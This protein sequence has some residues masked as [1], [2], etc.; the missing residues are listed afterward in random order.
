MMKEAQKLMNENSFRDDV[1][2]LFDGDF[3]KRNLTATEIPK[4]ILNLVE[5]D[6]ALRFEVIPVAFDSYDTLYL[7]T[8]A[9]NFKPINLFTT[10]NVENFLSHSLNLQCRILS[11]DGFNI[12]A[13]LEK[14][15]NLSDENLRRAWIKFYD[16]E[17]LTFN[18]FDKMLS[19][20]KK[21]NGRVI[22][23]SLTKSPTVDEIAKV[24]HFIPAKM[25]VRF[26]L[27]PVTF[28][29]ENNLI[30]VTSSSQTFDC[31]EEFSKILQMPCRFFLTL[32]E[33]IRDA[34]EFFYHFGG[35]N[36]KFSAKTDFDFLADG[37]FIDYRLLDRKIAP[38]ILQKIPMDVALKF[39]LVPLSF[40][41]EDNLILVTDSPNT[42]K[43]KNKLSELV[44]SDCKIL[45]TDVDTFADTLE[46]AYHLSENFSEPDG[47]WANLRWHFFMAYH[48]D[49][50][51]DLKK[52][53]E[54]DAYF[55]NFQIEYA[56]KFDLMVIRQLRRENISPDDVGLVEN[57]RAQCREILSAE[58]CDNL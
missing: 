35:L 43:L 30:L 48:P 2:D 16:F 29:G 54:Y 23:N 15:Y 47:E 57:V 9:E 1:E 8:A 14:Y 3:F 34:L 13:A 33:N 12:Q 26:S 46:T 5:P 17:R 6:F 38:E 20:A 7:V 4:N 19:W 22:K 39:H 21:F 18:N 58:I 31:V 45:M 44:R 24:L 55:K 50:L 51:V 25:A 10:L 11:T 27:I 42:I 49:I 56:N 52:F 32:D 37:N 41:C 40:D 53:G 36:K 28:D